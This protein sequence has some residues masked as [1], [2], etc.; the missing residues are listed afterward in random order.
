MGT[1]GLGRSEPQATLQLLSRLLDRTYRVPVV[2]LDWRVLPALRTTD[3]CLPEVMELRHR[4]T[5]VLVAHVGESF[6]GENCYTSR[7]CH[8]PI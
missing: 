3:H 6:R 7:I 4:E 5:I 8:V 2:R 1:L